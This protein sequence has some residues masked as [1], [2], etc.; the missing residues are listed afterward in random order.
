MA[1]F[2]PVSKHPARA[3]QAW[4]I[5]VGAAMNRQTLTYEGLS[6]K[7]YKKKAVGVLDKILGHI[8]FYCIEQGLPPLT[9]IVVGKG[10]STPGQDIPLDT[11]ALD[12]ARE[13]VYS[14]DWYDEY[15]PTEQ[16]L[17]AA[18]KAAMA[19][20][21]LVAVPDAPAKRAKR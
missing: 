9:S 5:L 19:P 16:E 8:A 11:K 4:V 14:Y 3:L 18:M 7:M 20:A 2:N 6:V 10:R 12:G 21:E 1:Q 17:A 13:R 15:P